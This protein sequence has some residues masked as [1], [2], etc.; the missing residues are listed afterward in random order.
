MSERTNVGDSAR[1]PVPEVPE[2]EVTHWFFFTPKIGGKIVVFI[3]LGDRFLGLYKNRL[4][5]ENSRYIEIL[6]SYRL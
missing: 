4:L 2:A 5:V 6:N 3:K 1:S